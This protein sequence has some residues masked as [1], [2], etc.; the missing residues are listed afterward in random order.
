M[1]AALLA[2][3]PDESVKEE[4]LRELGAERAAALKGALVGA[5]VDAARI[6]T[7]DGT[8]GAAGEGSLLELRLRE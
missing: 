3:M 5:G 8:D 6:F 7:V 4:W 1:E 2:E